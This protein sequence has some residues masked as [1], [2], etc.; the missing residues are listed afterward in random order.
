MK[1]LSVITGTADDLTAQTW[2]A[3]V[4]TTTAVG[5]GVNVAFRSVAT[6]KFYSGG[7][8]WNDA[9]HKW[10]STIYSS[11]TKVWQADPIGL[12]TF[13][14]DNNPPD[15]Q[16]EIIARARDNAGNYETAYAT[17]T[18]T[19]DRTA[20]VS[21]VTSPAAESYVPTMTA[22]TGTATE[23]T[24]GLRQVAVIFSYNDGGTDYN[25]TG[26]SWT[27]DAYSLLVTKAGETGV[28]TWSIAITTGLVQGIR[29]AVTTTAQ[30]QALNTETA[31]VTVYFRCDRVGPLVVI[32]TPTGTSQARWQRRCSSPSWASGPART[33]SAESRWGPCGLN[34]RES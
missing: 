9:A 7:S 30:D 23:A 31:P 11:T 1:A 21:L 32:S 14:A 27:T 6:G 26:S 10:F 28:S 25:W 29:Y 24:A 8:V 16:Y 33:C 19:W 34:S 15:G 22:I 3:G 2:A 5:D 4:S 13:T 18:F 20:P 17:R 12:Q